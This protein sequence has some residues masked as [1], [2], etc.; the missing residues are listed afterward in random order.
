M[1]A[2]LIS[3]GELK[4]RRPTKEEF[5]KLYDRKLM[6]WIRGMAPQLSIEDSE[7]ILQGFYLDFLGRNYIYEYDPKRSTFSGF[8]FVAI[9]SHVQNALIKNSASKLTTSLEKSEDQRSSLIIEYFSVMKNRD[10]RYKEKVGEYLDD[11]GNTL[12]PGLK[13]VYKLLRL[14]FKNKEIA[15]KLKE[16]VT[17]INYKKY[18]I[19]KQGQ[20]FCKQYPFEL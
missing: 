5:I 11:F 19:R 18:K 14:G 13:E 16:K 12:A 20:L 4:Y 2:N 7:D 9:R 1:E 8:I 15:E 17:S 3:K 10:K 6:E